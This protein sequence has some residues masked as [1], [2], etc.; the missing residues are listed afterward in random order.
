MNRILYTLLVLLFGSL[1]SSAQTSDYLSVKAG[2][3]FT[4]LKYTSTDGLFATNNVLGSFNAT[5]FTIGFSKEIVPNFNF[6]LTYQRITVADINLTSSAGTYTENHQGFQLPLIITYLFQPDTKKLRLNFGA[7]AEYTSFGVDQKLISSGG[8]VTSTNDSVTKFDLLVTPGI[9]YEVM[10]NLYLNYN[11]HY[12]FI[13]SGFN[14]NSH[15]LFIKYTFKKTS[16]K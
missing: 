7:G 11:F 13:A 5:G 1:Y 12:S 10:P 8:A 14:S 15:Q 2:Y 6:D 9:Q 3:N 16:K 4:H